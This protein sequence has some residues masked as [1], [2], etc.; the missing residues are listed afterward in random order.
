MSTNRRFK[1]NGNVS[2]STGCVTLSLGVF[3]KNNH[4]NE[5]PWREWELFS[6]FLACC[7]VI[8]VGLK[9]CL[10]FI[11]ARGRAAID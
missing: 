11:D 9:Y 3:G 1:S 5:I 2:Q 8:R 6:E 4:F 10:G 7:I